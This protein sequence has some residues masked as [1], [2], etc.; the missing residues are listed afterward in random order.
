VHPERELLVI[1]RRS[2]VCDDCGELGGGNDEHDDGSAL[3]LTLVFV[4]IVSLMVLPVMGYIMAVTRT[5]RVLVDRA[6]RVEAVK[7]G[8]RVAMVNP[9]QLYAACVASGR[10][11]AVALA[12][13]PGLGIASNCTTTQD[14]LQEVPSNLRWAVTTTQAGS[15]A[16][17]PAAYAN[18]DV[19]TP[20]LNGMISPLWCTSMNAVPKLSCGKPY[21]NNG[22]ADTSAWTVDS[23]ATSVGSKIF[24]PQLP[25]FSNSLRSA[26]AKDLLTGAVPCKIYFPGKYIDDVVITDSTPVYFV[27]GVYYFE[28]TLRISGDANV[29]VGAG[30]TPGCT[31]SDAIAVSDTVNAPLDA[32]S[33]GVG[34]TFVFGDA[35]RFV[36]DTATAGAAAGAS[37]VFNR[38]LVGTTDPLAVL[39]NISIM[40]ANGVWNGTTTSALD[41]PTQLHVPVALVSGTTPADPWTQTYKAS[42]LVSTLTPPVSCAPPPTPTTPACPIIDFNFA[43]AA[44]VSVKIPGYIAVPQ[45][46]VSIQTMAAATANKTVSFGGGI[47]AAQMLVSASTPQ[48]LQIGLLNPV[49]QKTF[50][51]TTTTTSGAPQMTSVALVQ[52][53]ETGGYA[54]NSWIVEGP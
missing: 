38:R 31:D 2:R 47:L 27:S 29:V 9:V 23:S 6:S 45:G 54:V 12:V 7:G 43:T 22:V 18:T 44:K 46:S 5:N 15:N 14:A 3:I 50:K 41:L 40:S 1:G 48:S 49:V 32:Y 37:I 16:L 20:E 52:V 51:I 10:T 4:L 25:P 19:S 17:I 34:G 36:V 21:P 33:N 28:K 26:T 39:N 13:P 24:S 42:T 53:N 8:L 11:S 35:G 30:A